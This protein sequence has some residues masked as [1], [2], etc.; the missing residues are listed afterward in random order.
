[1]AQ[2]EAQLLAWMGTDARRWTEEFKDRIEADV[3]LLD[4]REWLA[5]WFANAIM[6]GYNARDREPKEYLPHERG[7]DAAAADEAPSPHPKDCV[8][9]GFDRSAS[10]SANEYVGYCAEKK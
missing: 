8:C 1:M 9:G 3:R 7:Q 5:G 10:H 2:T 4:D 6:A